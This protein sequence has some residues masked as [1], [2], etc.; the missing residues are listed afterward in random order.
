M[1]IIIIILDTYSFSRK[2][3][4]YFEQ[5]WHSDGH[6]DGLL[7][8]LLGHIQSGDVGPFDVGFLHD[9]RSFQLGHHLLLLGIIAVIV[10]G[11]VFGVVF[12][13]LITVA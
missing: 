2:E 13:F 9:D 5:M 7:Q 10:V 12:A 4:S 3:M 8:R 11:V 1:S 6:D